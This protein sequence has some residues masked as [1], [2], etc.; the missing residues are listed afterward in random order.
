VVC[1]YFYNYIAYGQRAKEYL[2]SLGADPAKITIFLNDVNRAYFTKQALFLRPNRQQ[3]RKQLHITSPYV[4]LFVGQLIKRKGV[5]DL[6][7]AFGIF[8]RKHKDWS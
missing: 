2:Q 5:I 7:S 4:F 1:A 6:L 3:L 8:A